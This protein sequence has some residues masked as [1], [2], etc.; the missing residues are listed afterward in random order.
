MKK[1]KRIRYTRRVLIYTTLTLF[2]VFAIADFYF[3][4]AGVP[5]FFKASIRSKFRKRGLILTFDDAKCGVL[6]GLILKNPHCS[7]GDPRIYP[8]ISAVSMVLYPRFSFSSSYLFTV[9]SVIVHGGEAILPLFPESGVEGAQDTLEIENMEAMIK[10]D[11]N[12]FDL[13]WLTGNIWKLKVSIAGRIDNLFSKK[14]KGWFSKKSKNDNKLFDSAALMSSYS[15]QARALLWRKYKDFSAKARWYAKKPSCDISFNLDPLNFDATK[16]HVD[17]NIPKMAYGTQEIEG[18][19]ATISVKEDILVVDNCFI[20][21]PDGDSINLTGT[22]D[23]VRSRVTGK[24]KASLT[25]KTIIALCKMKQIEIPPK[26]KILSPVSLS[27]DIKNHSIHSTSELF[28]L[29]LGGDRL[30]YA[31]VAINDLRATGV[32]TNTSFEVHDSELLLDG[33]KLKVAMTCQPSSKSL[34]VDVHCFGPPIFVP[35]LLGAGSGRLIK[36]ILGRFTFPKNNRDVDLNLSTHVSWDG[37]LFYMVKGN[38][39]VKGFKYYKTKFTSGDSA[40]ILDS[41]GL[42][43]FHNMY[44]Y[45]KNGWAKVAM[46]YIDTPGIIYHAPSPFYRSNTGRE[47]K[48][49]TDFAGI[50]SG[51]DVL[52]CIFPKWS[53]KM[54]DLSSLADFSAHGV[55][56]F[57]EMEK[58]NFNVNVAKS[59]AGW[60]GV[61]ITD[62]SYKLQA[63]NLDMT[64]K[65]VKGKVYSGDL[66]LDYATNFKTSKGHVNLKLIDAEFPPLAKKIGWELSSGKGVISLS[67]NAKLSK[68]VNGRM[69]LYGKGQADVRGANL[70]EVP[71][72]RYF[73]KAASRWT[74]G[75]WGVISDMKADFKFEGDHL[76]TD[77]IHTNGNVIALSGKGKHYWRT[78]DYDFIIHAEI[79]K[80]ALPYKILSKFLYPLAGLMERRVVRKNGKITMKKVK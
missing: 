41:N 65:K 69:L 66:T 17:L 52:N 15:Y 14:V 72:L 50:M 46:M 10:V 63:K 22:L 75:N 73:G 12:G 32:V 28:T 43:L 54:L 61:P 13:T 26:L 70:W 24:A 68:D 49:M 34:D 6:N 42:I 71:I 74:A 57:H 64:I 20:K 56:D 51:E 21:S 40:F 36:D 58:T 29:T 44:L 25:P 11:E 30:E 67:T 60:N 7:G 59:I 62:L 23:A 33:V 48:F 4:T 55:I 37:P 19:N 31:K 18:G 27:V 47:D 16:L 53:S 80:S 3:E 79:F 8:S 1:P 78:G 5:D 2:I 9:D 45:Q 77:N 35:K 76:S 38:V 39:L